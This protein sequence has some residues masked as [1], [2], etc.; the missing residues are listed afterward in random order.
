MVMVAFCECFGEAQV[1]PI[2]SNLSHIS[3]E[4]QTKYQNA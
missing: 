4:R 1:S 2:C 3:N